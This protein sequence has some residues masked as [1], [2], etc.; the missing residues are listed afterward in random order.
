MKKL[1]PLLV[2]AA[3]LVSC[4]QVQK[5]IVITNA[6]LEERQNE[7]VRIEAA[8]LG[9]T[10]DNKGSFV[11]R[12]AQGNEVPYQ[13]NDSA[14]QPYEILFL[15]SV[16]GGMQALYTWEKGKPKAVTPKVFARYIPERK[17]DFAWENEYAA[18][19]MYGPQLADENPSNGVDLW[20]KKTDELVVDSFYYRELSQGFSYHINWGKGLDCYKVGHTLGC[21]GI[22]PYEGDSLLVGDHYTDWKI[23]QAGPLQTTFRLTYPQITLTITATAGALFNRCEV[24]YQPEFISDS[25]HLA[26]GIYLHDV[27]DN[28]SYAEQG[29]WVAYAENAVSDAGEPQ[30]RNYAAVVLPSADSIVL[31][32]DHVLCL[33]PYEVGDTLT[34]Y[35]AGGWSQYQVLTDEGDWVDL[36]PTDSDWFSAV[37]TMSRRLRYPP[38]QVEVQE[39]SH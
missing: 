9:L 35:F 5:Q 37:A 15:A 14:N 10:A 27:M 19:R 1:F 26:A 31:Q 6:S 28:L 3:C 16:K 23:L 12:D 38:L 30:G 21:G 36:F 32:N 39:A 11:L 18:F 2:V 33:A 25:L 20:L 34:Y 4:H 17:D 8:Q 7:M 24:V 13:V 22:A 29:V